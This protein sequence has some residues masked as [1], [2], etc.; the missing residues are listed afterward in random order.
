MNHNS[1][2]L[3]S[4]DETTTPVRE[5]LKRLFAVPFDQLTHNCLLLA[6]DELGHVLAAAVFAPQEA[7]NATVYGPEADADALR[8]KMNTIFA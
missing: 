3:Y 4:P 7:S 1:Y 6:K 8:V 5:N 2:F